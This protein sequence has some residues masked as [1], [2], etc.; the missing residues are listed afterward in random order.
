MIINGVCVCVCM[1]AFVCACKC[2]CACTYV[3]VCVHVCMCVFAQCHVSVCNNNIILLC[4][5]V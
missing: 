5:S 1:R 3:C 4:M 2:V